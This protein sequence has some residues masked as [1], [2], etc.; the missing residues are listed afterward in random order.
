MVMVFMAGEKNSVCARLHTAYEEMRREMSQPH[1]AAFMEAF[2]ADLKDDAFAYLPV[3]DEN[4]EAM[5]KGGPVKWLA[6]NTPKGRMIALFTSKEEVSRHPAGNRVGVKLSAF[7]RTALGGKD[8]AG[9]LVNPLDGHHGIPVE[10]RNL[11]ILAVRAGLA[12]PAA[13]QLHPRVVSDA[14]CHLWDIAVGVPTAVYDVSREVESLGGTDRLLLPVVEGWKKRMGSGP[15]GF[16]G[17]SDFLRAALNDV[18]ARGFIYGAMALKNPDKAQEVDVEKCID[19]VPGLR[20]DISQ[21]VD[22]YLVLLSDAARGDM[23]KPD[24]NQLQLLLALNVGI[25]AFGAFN[26]GLGWGVAKDAE[27]SGGAALEELRAH[28]QEWIANF[29]SR[30]HGKGDNAKMEDKENEDA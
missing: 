8:C 3:A 5:Q 12:G 1:Y 29:Q 13:P 22:E 20:A 17:P 19:A 28:Q 25:I 30:M 6:I 16:V 7:V 14:V 10:R 23:I 2:E 27:S 21:N 4:V 24:E 11:E 26:F 15:G 9:I 18:V